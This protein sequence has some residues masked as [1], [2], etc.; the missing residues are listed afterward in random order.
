MKT[1]RKVRT[2]EGNKVGPEDPQARISIPRVRWAPR[3][4]ESDQVNTLSSDQGD[5]AKGNT[6]MKK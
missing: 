4:D 3:R 2:T 6:E 1:R 5:T